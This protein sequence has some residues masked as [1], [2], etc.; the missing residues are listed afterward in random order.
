MAGMDTNV[1]GPRSSGDDRL[2][3]ATFFQSDNELGV[4]LDRYWEGASPGWYPDPDTPTIMRFWDGT[5]W[6][7]TVTVFPS[8]TSPLVGMLPARSMATP[9]RARIV[10]ELR[11]HFRLY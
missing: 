7:E 11:E 6:S 4:D 5:S 9:K 3:K 1:G 8:A 10:S 2:G